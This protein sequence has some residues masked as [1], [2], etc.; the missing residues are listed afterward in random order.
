MEKLFHCLTCKQ[1]TFNCKTL[2]FECK[3]NN[4]EPD[5]L[6]YAFERKICD[7]WEVRDNGNN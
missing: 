6:V 1:F 4:A 7:K 3:I 2:K 5:E